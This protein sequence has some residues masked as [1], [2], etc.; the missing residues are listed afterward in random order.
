MCTR[1]A[2]NYSKWGPEIK[3]GILAKT[4]LLP[5]AGRGRFT[6]YLIPPYPGFRCQRLYEA[7]CRLAVLSDEMGKRHGDSMQGR[8]RFPAFEVS[9]KHPENTENSCF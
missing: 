8:G 6:S 5:P 2:L 3:S 4:A 7:S 9:G 1:L